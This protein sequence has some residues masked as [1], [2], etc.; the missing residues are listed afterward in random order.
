M[1]EIYCS[2]C[3]KRLSIDE[4]ICSNCGS[5]KKH[6]KLRLEEK[7]EFHDQIKGKAKESGS[8]KLLREFKVGD[9]FYRKDGKWNDLE[10]IVDY[11]NDSYRL[12]Q[13]P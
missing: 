1:E 13:N 6:I 11:E 7:I 3:Q 2:D 4:I 5:K 10:R 9:D 12:S 8:N